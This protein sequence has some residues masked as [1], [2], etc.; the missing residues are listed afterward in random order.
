VIVLQVGKQDE[1]RTVR[2]RY[3]AMRLWLSRGSGISVREQLVSQI[4]LSILSADLKPAQRLPSTRELARRFHVHPNT[5]SAGY[6]QLARDNWVEFRKGSGIYVRQQ[7]P[8]ESP[9]ETVLDR[10]IADFFLAVR[11]LD[12]PLSAVRARLKQWME[13]QPPDHFLLIE[14]DPEVAAIVVSELRDHLSL[15]IQTC[16][17][18]ECNSPAVFETSIPMVLS[19]RSKAAQHLVPEHTELL[20]LQLRSAANSLAPY[21]PVPSTA[22]IAIASRWQPFLK[23]ARTMLLAAGFHP[24]S[25]L[26]RDVAKPNWRRGLNQAAAVICDKS[27]AQSLNGAFR[28]IAFPLIAEASLKELAAFEQ[29]LDPHT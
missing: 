18:S 17:F 12:T 13:V 11:K 24:D 28:V 1:R 3:S 16:A 25:L 8:Q 20:T 15:P 14:D 29:F 10:L 27:T 22:L 4:V 23:N 5:I 9:P 7:K 6:R 2:V 19:I 26:L 21:L